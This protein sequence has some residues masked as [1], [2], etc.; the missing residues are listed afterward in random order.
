MKRKL[1]IAVLTVLV[2]FIAIQ[3]YQ[4]TMNKDGGKPYET[5]FD[6]TYNVP[7]DIQQMLRASCYDCHSNNTNYAWYDYIQPAR[8]FVE[9][10]I[11]EGKEDLNFN[12]WGAYSQRKQERLLASIKK[13]IEM[14]KM[15]L[16]SYIAIKKNKELSDTDIDIIANWLDKTITNAAQKL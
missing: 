2:L 11:K 8:F 1:K 3:F 7:A 15:P 9:D 6:R 13:Q 5:D 16:R 4:P 14:R 12:E 10:H